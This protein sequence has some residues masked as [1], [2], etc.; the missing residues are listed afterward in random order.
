MLFYKLFYFS[1]SKYSNLY[2]LILLLPLPHLLFES[3]LAY[4]MFA[5]WGTRGACRQATKGTQKGHK[6]DTKRI[7]KTQYF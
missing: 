5:A 6:R 3:R 2:I 4:C 7:G 1:I